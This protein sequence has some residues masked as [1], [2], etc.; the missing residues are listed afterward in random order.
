[1]GKP[2]ALV[3]YDTFGKHVPNDE[4]R[5]KVLEMVACGMEPEDIAYV[6]HCT[7]YEVTLHY[8]EEI[9][10]GP[11]ITTGQVAHGL[12][13]NAIKNGDV[14]AQQF[15]LK[16]RAGWMPPQK[17]ELTGKD[18]GPVAIEERKKT[19][20]SVIDLLMKSVDPRKNDPVSQ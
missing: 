20:D 18:G 7:P 5:L 2:D 3:V 16:N 19:V 4:L 8:K 15:W 10:R 1:M 17:V 12:L 14:A 13:E 9:E 6:F 11:R